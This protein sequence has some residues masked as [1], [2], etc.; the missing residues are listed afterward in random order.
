MDVNTMRAVLNT[1]EKI[2]VSGKDNHGYVLGLIQLFEKEIAKEVA[3]END[4][5]PED[6]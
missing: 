5:D 6:G 2:S 4:Q 1:L 3:K